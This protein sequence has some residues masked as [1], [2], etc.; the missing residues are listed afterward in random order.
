MFQNI[1]AKTY[2]GLLSCMISTMATA[3]TNKSHRKMENLTFDNLALRVLPIDPQK[4]VSPTGIPDRFTR[5][6]RDAC[7]S[8]VKPTPLQ[9]PKVVAVSPS[10]LECLGLNPEAAVKDVN[11]VEYMSGN[12][13][14][15]GEFRDQGDAKW[16]VTR[17]SL[18]G[19]NDTPCGRPA[20]GRPIG[21]LQG[22]IGVF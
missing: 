22:V 8:K 19:H 9:N 3:N 12:R 5:Q 18:W 4:E 6:V 20:P 21:R 14:I 16:I 10:A 17:R 13:V 1:H 2:A 15:P 7:F 11:F